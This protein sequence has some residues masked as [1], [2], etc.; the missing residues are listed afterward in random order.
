MNSYS[1][2]S[3]GRRGPLARANVGSRGTGRRRVALGTVLRILGVALGLA[4]PMIM[5]PRVPHVSPWP[6]LLGL[7]PWTIGKYVLCPLRWHALSESGRA[8]RWHFAT[9]A[10]SELIGLLTPGHV[11]AD[12]WRMRRL[13]SVGM[14]KSHALAE[15]GLDRLVGAIGLAAFAGI[16]A[17]T[18]PIRMVLCSLTV[19]GAALAVGLIVRLVRPE[20]IPH[21]KLPHPHRLAH[22]LVL[23]VL[24]QG[25]IVILLLGSL[26]AIGYT[27]SPLELLGAFGASQVAAV[28]PGPHG[29]SP[30]DG[31]L[32]VALVALGVPWSAAV[33]AVALKA[34]LAWLPALAF[35]GGC[36]LLARRLGT[37]SRPVTAAAA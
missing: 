14:P 24:Y 34:L 2:L 1:A 21:R 18:L 4:V 32:V 36:L 31:A 3:S 35:G 33:G 8:R 12:V 17:T 15:V 6:I 25:S 16:A 30:R 27:A 19:A 13:V 20:W 7:V 29:A 26:L 5:L 23:S 11:G 37:I 9:Y 22:G 10:E 28:V